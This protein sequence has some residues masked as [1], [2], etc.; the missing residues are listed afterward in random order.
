M[1]Y[2][3][4]GDAIQIATPEG[5][6]H[7]EAAFICEHIQQNSLDSVAVLFR[8]NA[9]SALLEQCL[10]KEGIPYTV[11][12]GVTFF[13]RK[14]IYQMVFFLAA[15]FCNNLEA[16]I[17]FPKNDKKGLPSFTG[18][19]NLPT[20]EF[21]KPSRYLGAA[22]FSKLEL[23]YRTTQKPDLVKVAREFE[24][25]LDRRFRPG[26]RDLADML[27]QMREQ[28]DTPKDA[29][30]WAFHHVYDEQLRLDTDTNEDAYHNK[31]ASITVLMEISEKYSSIPEFVD[32]CMEQLFLDSK[33]KTT[34]AVQLMT[35]HSAKGLEFKH[36]YVLG[37]NDRF[38]P[39]ARG[40]L[41]EER[42]VFYVAVT[43]AEDKLILSSPSGLD[44]YGKTLTPS[45]F[46]A[47]I[48]E[49]TL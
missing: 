5:G 46:L 34:A 11:R 20:I 18:I 47:E 29:L 7:G 2:D 3:L 10:I 31:V 26:A 40:N 16:V 41:D 8:T 45:G 21:G 44:F 14:E 19:G 25:A 43:R 12:G 37:L 30:G 13:S 22:S 27:E 9:Q 39:H 4:V 24:G 49:L 6:F 33:I 35:I 36:V 48:S 17:G 15:A 28:V 38:L 23:L 32:Y 1:I 42:R